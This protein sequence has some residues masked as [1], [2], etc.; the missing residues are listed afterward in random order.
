M[1][2]LT[3]KNFEEEVL[4]SKVP[5]MVDFWSEWCAPCKVQMPLVEEMAEEYGDKMRFG[6][7]E[8]GDNPEIPAK[9]QILSIPAIAVFKYGKLLELKT[10]L[11]KKESLKKMVEKVIAD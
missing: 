1:I 6:K 3:D 7:L 5:V 10:G 8:A 4:G 2:I 11:Q 9:Y